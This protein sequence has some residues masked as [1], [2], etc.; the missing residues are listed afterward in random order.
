M[1]TISKFFTKTV[2]TGSS[3]SNPGNVVTDIPPV[4]NP[5]S[6]GGVNLFTKLS[7]VSD[8]NYIGKNGFVPVVVDESNLELQPLPQFEEYRLISGGVVQWT[9]TG[10]VFNV[11]SAIYKIGGTIYQTVP[12]QKTLAT[13]D[14]TDN[15]ID[16]LAVDV[17]GVVVIIAG[18]PSATPVK[19]Q[20]DPSI[21]LEL[22]SI[23]VIAA[24]TTPTLTEEVIYDENTEWTGS[25]TGTGTV[26]F[27]SAVDPFQ[28]AVSIETTNIQNGLK[29]RLTSAIDVDISTFQT[30]G[31]QIKLKAQLF[32]GQNIGITFLNS[33]GVPVSNQIM[34]NLNSIDKVNLNYQFVGIALNSLTFTSNLVRS[35]EFEFIRTKGSSTH[36]G[37]FLDIIKLEGGINPPVTVSS[38]LNLSDT[39]N[40]Y[41]G[42]GGKTVAVKADASGLEFVVGG[43]GGVQSVTGDG[44]DNTDPDNPIIAISP[45]DLTQ[46]AATNGQVIT[47]VDANSRFE[48][49][50]PSG[51]G[52][53][54]DATTHIYRD[55]KV[56]IGQTILPSKA[57]FVVKAV[58]AIG[59]HNP[60]QF[61][62]SDGSQALVI[63]QLGFIVTGNS[64]LKALNGPTFKGTGTA[65]SLTVFRVYNGNETEF[66]EMRAN[67]SFRINRQNQ[68][69]FVGNPTINASNGSTIKGSGTVKTQVSFMVINGNETDRFEI[70]GDG[71]MVSE[72]T[73]NQ[74]TD[75]LITGAFWNDSGTVKIS[76]G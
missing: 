75:P 37:Y 26:A 72:R 48:P 39:P 47:W 29:V 66:F 56:V 6:S 53:W 52:L 54:T 31:F 69:L 34:S 27:N 9:G 51:G 64:A 4:V 41:S 7:D 71:L 76:A 3:P 57:T 42:Q 70:R 45:Y 74:T 25:T 19:P 22:T 44:V 21:Q 59:G 63:N 36:L 68:G 65:A 17:N 1:V 5:P 40:S 10:Y 46:E 38:F 20:V 30:F 12:S 18:V 14:P 28:G 8:S 49:V 55:G 60:F 16:V 50:T 2:I 11:S 24:S 58:S 32:A 43:G 13:P 73:Y 61:L 35:V 33:A 67:G 23:L 15:R 62:L